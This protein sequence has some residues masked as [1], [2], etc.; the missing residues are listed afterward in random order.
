MTYMKRMKVIYF[1]GGQIETANGT[2]EA[3]I[4]Q[5]TKEKFHDKG[6]F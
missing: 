3:I 5:A 1:L 4:L 2:L 6:F